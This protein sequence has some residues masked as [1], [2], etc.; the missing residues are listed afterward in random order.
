MEG[1]V[2]VPRNHRVGA[3]ARH[4]PG[5]GGPRGHSRQYQ[6]RPHSRPAQQTQHGAA[7]SHTI[8]LGPLLLPARSRHLH[9]KSS[10]AWA[11]KS[12][13]HN[14]DVE[15]YCHHSSLERELQL[16][17]SWAVCETRHMSQTKPK[18]EK[19]LNQYLPNKITICSVNLLIFRSCPYHCTVLMC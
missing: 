4:Q 5:Q 19:Y 7:Q 16:G 10:C 13:P 2:R 3:D 6:C 12:C 1:G 14:E 15:Q 17:P 18:Y 11:I 8:S 9:Q